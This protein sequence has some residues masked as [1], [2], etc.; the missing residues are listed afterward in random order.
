ML[1][2]IFTLSNW[3]RDRG[4]NVR[5][6][7]RSHRCCQVRLRTG[8]QEPLPS[9]L[10]RFS[11]CMACSRCYKFIKHHYKPRSRKTPLC[12]NSEVAGGALLQS[13]PCVCMKRARSTMLQVVRF[14][15]MV[16]AKIRR[17]R[18]YV[19]ERP[20]KNLHDCHVMNQLR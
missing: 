3:R 14:E 16:I 12:L 6:Q 15:S 4:A 8:H 11:L 7:R 17:E 19:R 10:T 20:I 1:P 18:I 9:V 2:L 5:H 13:L